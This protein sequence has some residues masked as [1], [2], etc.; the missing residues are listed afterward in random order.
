MAIIKHKVEI[1]TGTLKAAVIKSLEYYLCNVLAKQYGKMS[2]AEMRVYALLSMLVIQYTDEYNREC[3][4]LLA[5]RLGKITA[6]KRMPAMDS[7]YSGMDAYTGELTEPFNFTDRNLQ[8][9]MG[10][11]RNNLRKQEWMI[12]PDKNG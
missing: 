9:C 12:T 4:K 7:L 10:V 5:Q 11:M 2:F 8:M 3:D 6:A 1:P